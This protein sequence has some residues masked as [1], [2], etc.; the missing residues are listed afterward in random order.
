L[1]SVAK[2]A[3]DKACAVGN[4]GRIVLYEQDE[5]AEYEVVD[6]G[7]R[8]F[9]RLSSGAFIDDTVGCVAGQQWAIWQTTDG[10]VSWTKTS[11]P[12][13]DC[14][15]DQVI[16][17]IAFSASGNHGVAVGSNGFV[18][19][20][21]DAGMTWT[22]LDNEFGTVD[23]HAV[24]FAPSEEVV[25]AV[26]EDGAFWKSGNWGQFWRG[27]NGPGSESLFGVSFSSDSEGYVVGANKKVYRTT[28]AGGSWAAVTVSG[29]G[30]ENLRD[31]QTWGDG[32]QAV[33]VGQNGLVFEKTGTSFELVDTE[34]GVT[35]ELFDVQVFI[36]GMDVDLRICGDNGV[37]MFRDAGNWTQPRT[38]STRTLRKVSFQSPD[39]GFVIGQNF[40]I[41]EYSD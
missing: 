6:T 25:Y 8:Y 13:W 21:A 17:D 28:S 10:G 16:N 38:Y 24:A 9:S 18:A 15:L 39:Q 41:F 4:F 3:S 2:V 20:T 23:F 32:S 36:N 40:Q 35:D 29:G 19:Y 37:A 26:G 11:D 7:S 1:Y 33:A 27:A 30:Q 22:K 5:Q 31:V 34:L 12:E 14:D